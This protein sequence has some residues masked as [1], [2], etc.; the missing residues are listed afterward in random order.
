M[1]QYLTPLLD[2]LTI[3]EEYYVSTFKKVYY[4][5]MRSKFGLVN[6]LK[7]DLDDNVL[8]DEKL[9]DLFLD[10]LESTGS[11]LTNAFRNLSLVVKSVNDSQEVEKQISNYINI[12]MSEGNSLGYEDLRKESK[13]LLHNPNIQYCL[14]LMEESKDQFAYLKKSDKIKAFVQF[15]ERYEKTKVRLFKLD[16]LMGFL[17]VFHLLKNLSK[18]EKS[19][20]DKK[21]WRKFFEAYV[22]RIKHDLNDKKDKD[23]LE[24][25]F[26]LMN[27]NNP[28]FILRNHLA[29]KAIAE[30]EKGNTDEIRKIIYLIENPF[31]DI[32]KEKISDLEFYYR[33]PRKEERCR[34]I[35]CSS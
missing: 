2:L 25:R 27:S 28:K 19:V 31:E 22:Q 15:I 9:V 7:N 17:I 16:L 29:Q 14:Q 11:D 30:A 32:D 34:Q 18:E 35:T 26:K 20:Y 1:L 23:G 12:M 33:L 13:E 3:Q 10:T 5:K 4:D 21:K 24:Q 8:S 6:E